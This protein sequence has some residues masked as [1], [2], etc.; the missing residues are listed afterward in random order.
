MLHPVAVLQPAALSSTDAVAKCQKTRL[1][2]SLLKRP[3]KN[4]SVSAPPSAERFNGKGNE[5][6]KECKVGEAFGGAQQP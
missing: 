4:A 6:A 1:S 3:H 5:C 2:Q